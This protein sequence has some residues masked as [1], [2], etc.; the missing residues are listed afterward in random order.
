MKQEDKDTIKKLKHP[1]KNFSN[2]DELR[3]FL[4]HEIYSKVS[5]KN[6]TLIDKYSRWRVKNNQFD[7]SNVLS[8]AGDI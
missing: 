2:L 5:L 1:I 8:S 4:S 3:K 6:E 7:S